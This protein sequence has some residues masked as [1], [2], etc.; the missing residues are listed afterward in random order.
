MTDELRWVVLQSFGSG[1]EADMARQTLEEEE[2]PV[3][4]RSNHAG[5]TGASFQGAIMGGVELLVPQQKLAAA[6]ELIGSDD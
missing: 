3:L 6:R 1:L 4:V 2:I 5:I